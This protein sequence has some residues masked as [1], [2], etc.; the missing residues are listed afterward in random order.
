MARPDFTLKG[1]EFKGSNRYFGQEFWSI[2]VWA[3]RPLTSMSGTSYMGALNWSH[4]TSLQCRNSTECESC[5]PPFR[6]LQ[7][8]LT[9]IDRNWSLVSHGR[10]LLGD[11]FIQIQKYL[12][13]DAVCR[14]LLEGN[15]A[16][17]GRFAQLCK[18]LGTVRILRKSIAVILPCTHQ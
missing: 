5:S 9:G 8:M 10:S 1:A 3:G 4:V 14:E 13:D 18:G 6:E 11:C 16:F 17:G 12:G 15:I 2:E 7:R